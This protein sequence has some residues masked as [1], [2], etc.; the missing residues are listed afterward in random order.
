MTCAANL[1]AGRCRP[2]RGCGVCRLIRGGMLRRGRHDAS[3]A[4]AV[5]RF[6]VGDDVAHSAAPAEANRSERS[7]ERAWSV[8]SRDTDR[9]R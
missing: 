8:W 1:S 5:R 7:A 2:C 4:G 9:S 6:R 3:Q